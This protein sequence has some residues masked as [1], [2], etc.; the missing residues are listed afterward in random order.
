MTNVAPLH[1]LV[2]AGGKSQ[3]MQTDKAALE[4]GGIS[5]LERAMGLL[6]TE[7]AQVY[8]SVA[9]SQ[10]GN[11]LRS[12]YPQ[13][14]DQFEK[15]GPAAGLLSAHLHDPDAAW[16]VVACDM[17]MLTSAAINQL[18]VARDATM[19]ATAWAL[20]GEEGAEPLCAIY[21]PA[22]LAAFLEHV[23]AGG[24]PSPR[25]WLAAAA[26]LLLEQPADVKLAGVNTPAEFASVREQMN[27]H[28]DAPV[29]GSDRTT[30]G[31]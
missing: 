17:P 21:E 5:L 22:T 26:T 29:G 18:L 6:C 19:A 25:A 20:D 3:R 8:V 28:T 14:V 1:G 31:R 30:N 11:T 27:E 15:Q 7:L 4:L 2:L 23:V 13:I 9:A 12:G 10:S 16:L 24:N